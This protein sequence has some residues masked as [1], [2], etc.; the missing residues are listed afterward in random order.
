MTETC[1][2][3]PRWA[4]TLKEKGVREIAGNLVIDNS[5]FPGPPYGKGWDV[6]PVNCFSAPRDAFT[7]NNN[8]IQLDI[9]PSGKKG[10]GVFLAMEPATDYVSL[11]NSVTSGKDTD[12]DIV[13]LEYTTS[14]SL[15]ISGSI[16]PESPTITR[17][18]AVNHPAHFGGFVLRETLEAAGI[19]VRGD[20]LCARNCPKTVD[21]RARREKGECTTVAVYRSPRLADVIKVVNKLSNNLYAEL[22]LIATGRA[23]GATGTEESA[24]AALATLRRAGVD[25]SGLVMAD[26]SGLSR[27]D[28]LT[29]DSVARLL[30]IMA[31][32]PHARSFVDSLPVM[33]VDGTL[34]AR[35]KGSRAAE[36]VRAK[37][38]TM[39]H[40]RSLSGYMTTTRGERLVFSVFSNN[41]IGTSAVDTAMDRIILRLLDETPSKP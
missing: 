4:A 28:L 2:R 38:G 3:V 18:V 7:F 19:V 17:Y 32:G 41:H 12:R 21:V 29:P 15:S 20:I 23:Q 6:D 40:V 36:R 14:R 16:R 33:S 10:K 39:T 5:S 31:E 13:H 11:T 1:P 22:L 35:L 30:R 27:H 37:T 9:T 25:T 26:G 8:C 24:A 34:G